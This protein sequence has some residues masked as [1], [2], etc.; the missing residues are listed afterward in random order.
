M[1]FLILMTVLFVLLCALCVLLLFRPCAWKPL[2]VTLAAVLALGGVGLGAFALQVTREHGAPDRM[3]AEYGFSAD[4]A[5]YTYTEE[6]WGRYYAFEK[7]D[8]SVVGLYFYFQQND[9]FPIERYTTGWIP[10][11]EYPKEFQTLSEYHDYT[12]RLGMTPVVQS[13]AHGDETERFGVVCT[14]LNSITTNTHSIRFYDRYFAVV[15]SKAKPTFVQSD[16]LV[17]SNA[18]D[19]GASRWF[20]TFGLFSDRDDSKS[21]SFSDVV[22]LT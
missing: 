15:T 18:V 21:V 3:F 13:G 19:L 11:S 9:F 14:S 1:P 4:R 2:R 7:P 10:V 20:V 8:G 16:L 6:N 12:A 5:L 22:R 17:D